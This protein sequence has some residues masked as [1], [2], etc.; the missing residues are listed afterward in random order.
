[1]FETTNQIKY[2]PQTLRLVVFTN[3][4]NKLRHHLAP[5]ISMG[6][7]LRASAARRECSVQRS[8]GS[9]FWECLAA[10]P[11]VT[12]ISPVSRTANDSTTQGANNTI[13]LLRLFLVNKPHTPKHSWDWV[14]SAWNALGPLISILEYHLLRPTAPRA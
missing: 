10:K 6:P 7:S 1:M 3:L 11:K 4:A 5:P 12:E 13:L 14:G 9:V 2:L 8:V